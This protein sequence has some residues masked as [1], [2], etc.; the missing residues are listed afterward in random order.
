MKKKK[1][2]DLKTAMADLKFLDKKTV[3]NYKYGPRSTTYVGCFLY[4]FCAVET[5]K[6]LY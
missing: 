4:R 1:T 6:G 3:K 5:L 2:S